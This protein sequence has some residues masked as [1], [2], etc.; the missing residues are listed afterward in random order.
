[1][2]WQALKRETK[3]ILFKYILFKYCVDVENCKSFR[4]LGFIYT[5]IYIVFYLN[6]VLMWKIVSTSEISVIYIY[7]Y[8]DDCI[9]YRIWEILLICNSDKMTNHYN[10]QLP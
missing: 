10:S 2:I 8:I 4:D 3:I 5:H 1:M 9:L 7:I 6:I